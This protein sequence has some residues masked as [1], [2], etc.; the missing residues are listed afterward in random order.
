MRYKTL[1]IILLSLFCLHGCQ[2]ASKREKM[3]KITAPSEEYFREREPT[4]K[5]PRKV[6][7]RVSILK[8]VVNATAIEI[9]GNRLFVLD[10][11]KV[12]VYSLNDFQLLRKFGR[13]GRGPG[14]FVYHPIS[15]VKI[16]LFDDKILLQ[17][18]FKI[19]IF[20]QNGQ[21]LREKVIRSLMS[22]VVP[23]KD[24]FL[25]HSL[26]MPNQWAAGDEDFPPRKLI[27]LYSS[28]FKSIKK[29]WETTYPLESGLYPALKTSLLT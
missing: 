12:Y 28:D 7:K 1:A 2:E 10:Q 24:Q 3:R 11:E 5:G 22:Q 23:W 29:I 27:R 25:I 14:E 13:R 19:A 21:F 20:T 4:L 9:S 16:E 26:Q 17:R 8:E 15:Q 18:M 6:G